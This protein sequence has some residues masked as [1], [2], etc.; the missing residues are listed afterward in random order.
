[1][2]NK[3]FNSGSQSGLTSKLKARDKACR[4]ER[5]ALASISGAGEK[6][7]NDRLPQ[8]EI[9]SH[10]LA[11]LKSPMRAL[12]KLDPVHIREIVASIDALGFCAPILINKDGLIIDGLAR[13]EAA[14]LAGLSSVPCIAITHLSD[15]EQRVLRLALNR[16]AE[17]GDWD[18]DEL[19]I[20]FEELRLLEAPIELSGFAL[21][22]IDQ[23]VI[24]GEGDEIEASP[25]EPNADTVA[26]ARIGD[27]FQLGPHRLICGDATDGS[28]LQR[29]MGEEN[30]S[31]TVAR[32]VLTDEPYNVNISGN[33]TRGD[34]REFAM[35]SQG[36]DE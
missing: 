2:T 9:V 19:K 30:G 5:K 18:L 4:V 20:E 11:D 28:V 16:L 3:T 13:A 14:R 29:L 31:R 17:K 7:R 12:R 8:L 32:I 22:E 27:A 15:Q 33:V 6:R 23:I 21:D 24:C 25:L 36:N 35:A 26:I 10:Q 1:M 34:H